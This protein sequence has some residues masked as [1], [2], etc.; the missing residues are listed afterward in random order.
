MRKIPRVVVHMAAAVAINSSKLTVR[1]QPAAQVA[2]FSC[3]G[4]SRGFNANGKVGR[5]LQV[6]AMLVK[7]REVMKKQLS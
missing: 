4:K 2:F 1:C 7:K 5:R 6:N 3:W